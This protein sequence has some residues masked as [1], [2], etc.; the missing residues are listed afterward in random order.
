[1]AFSSSEGKLFFEDFL[2]HFAKPLGFKTFLD[3]GCGA[4]LYGKIIREVYNEQK[5]DLVGV[6]I[7]EEYVTRFNLASIYDRLCVEDIKL[8][9]R[10][11][12]VTPRDLIIAGDV[13]EHLTKEEAIEVVN[14][15]RSKCRFLWAALPLRMGRPWSVGYN[16]G[17]HEYVV[18]PA[19]RHLHDYTGDEIQECFK[20][21]W[22]VPYILTGSFLIEGDIR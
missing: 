16:Q 14:S 18:N 22:L 5:I 8:I 4:G 9:C 17:E 10:S 7:F 12:G 1:M 21:L 3:I 20:P 15:L 13:L 19:E 6:E 2:R 11:G